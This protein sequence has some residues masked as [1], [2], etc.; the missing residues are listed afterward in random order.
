MGCGKHLLEG[1]SARLFAPL[2]GPTLPT[3]LSLMDPNPGPPLEMILTGRLGT[4]LPLDRLDSTRAS[5][6]CT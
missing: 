6:S 2:T 4:V 1:L 5:S 3:R